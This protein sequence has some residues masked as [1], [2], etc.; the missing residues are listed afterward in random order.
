MKVPQVVRVQVH[1]VSYKG[2]GGDDFMLSNEN[3]LRP[4]WCSSLIKV[5]EILST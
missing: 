3:R 1:Q 5:D 2:G 4:F